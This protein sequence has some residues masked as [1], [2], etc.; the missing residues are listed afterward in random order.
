[1]GW[2]K[3]HS[4][5]VNF[6][7][8][9]RTIPLRGGGGGGGGAGVYH[10]HR[11]KALGKSSP[12][13]SLPARRQRH[14]IRLSALG[15]VR[16]CGMPQRSCCCSLSFALATLLPLVSSSS[17]H[18]QKN[19]AHTRP[20]IRSHTHAPTTTCRQTDRQ[21]ADTDRQT[22]RQTLGVAGGDGQRA[23]EGNHPWATWA[24]GRGRV[25]AH[26]VACVDTRLHTHTSTRTHTGARAHHNT[27]AAA[28]AAHTH[29]HLLLDSRE[30][31]LQV[32]LQHHASHYNF[33]L[34]SKTFPSRRLRVS[35]L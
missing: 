5:R 22:D 34:E 3:G 4:P 23:D 16:R 1:M 13:Q 19:F 9:T 8:E 26:V 27:A 7:T 30:N 35:Y 2:Q 20:A 18:A 12:C 6:S 21:T 17:C 15:S 29:T 25:S 14:M 24:T 10:S 31:F 11:P 33:I 28:A 32:C